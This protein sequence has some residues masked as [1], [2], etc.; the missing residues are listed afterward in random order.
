MQ[1]E[2]GDLINN[3]SKKDIEKIIK[4]ADKSKYSHL[5]ICIDNFDYSYFPRFISNDENIYKVI[6]NITCNNNMLSIVEIYNYRE[7]INKQLNEIRAYHIE[8]TN[9]QAKKNK[10]KVEEALEYATV[11][12]RGQY[13]KN[14]TEYISHPI[15][16]AEYVSRFKISRNLETLIIAAYLHDTIEDTKAT[17]Y[18]IVNIF[19]P[20]VASIVLELTTDEDLK[21]EIGK[22]KYLEIKMKNMS[23]WALVIKLCDRLANVSDLEYADEFF[24]NKYI[25]ETLEI[26]DYIV[27]HRNLS[28]THITIIRKILQHLIILNQLFPKDTVQLKESLSS[29]ENKMKLLMT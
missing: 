29:I 28:K 19:G 4:N 27:N 25:K 12:H 11:M 17:Y 6:N 22:T 2:R 13:R 21:N 23:S 7:D 1:L 16:V 24:R 14:G 8:P 5:L 10:T 18:D 15:K 26:I 9:Q 3:I 20:Q